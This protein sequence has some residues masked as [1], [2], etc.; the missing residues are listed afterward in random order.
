MTIEEEKRLYREAR[1]EYAAVYL[2]A[3]AIVVVGFATTELFSA[4]SLIPT[5]V[6]IIWALGIARFGRKQEQYL[7]AIEPQVNQM[8]SD[9]ISEHEAMKQLGCDKFYY[10]PFWAVC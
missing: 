4:G 5:T 8:V 2:V 7:L 10:K 1:K 6:L 3:L 9:G